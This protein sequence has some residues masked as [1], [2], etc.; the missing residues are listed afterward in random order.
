[1]L[2]AAVRRVR[3]TWAPEIVEAKAL[4]MGVRLSK[5][6]GLQ[7]VIIESDCQT[8]IN[9]LLKNTIFLSDLDNILSNILASCT[10]FSSL[11]WSHVKR[12]GNYVAHHLAKLIPF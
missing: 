12:D 5:K 6:F 3:A 10:S 8:V 9:M 7:H 11:I 2:F 1:M 4:E